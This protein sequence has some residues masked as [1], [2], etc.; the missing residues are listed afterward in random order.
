M[1]RLTQYKNDR[2]LTFR[3]ADYMLLRPIDRP[4]MNTLEAAENPPARGVLRRF[5]FH[6]RERSTL[7]FQ[8]ITNSV[9]DSSIDHQAESHHH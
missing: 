8:L 4:H 3:D 1:V 7:S 9:L 5:L 6:V 2:R